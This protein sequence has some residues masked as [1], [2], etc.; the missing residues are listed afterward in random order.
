M[1]KHTAASLHVLVGSPTIQSGPVEIMAEIA[2]L[3][4]YNSCGAP[5]LSSALGLAADCNA[6]FTTL[7]EPFYLNGPPANIVAC[8]MHFKAG[9]AMGPAPAV[10]TLRTAG[11]DPSETWL[12]G[13]CADFLL[14]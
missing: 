10:L 14:D 6:L 13:L 5:K 9:G 12:A 11:G 1:R 7:Q 4:Q 8:P 2:S 3:K